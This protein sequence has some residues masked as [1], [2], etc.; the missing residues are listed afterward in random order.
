M[1]AFRFHV[2]G[3]QVGT[4]ILEGP[5]VIQKQIKEVEVLL[6]SLPDALFHAIKI[7]QVG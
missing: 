5:E 7:N 2:R 3:S 4:L 6:S 1:R